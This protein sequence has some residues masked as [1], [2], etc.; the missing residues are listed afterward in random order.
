M[1]EPPTFP[2]ELWEHCISFIA[3]DTGAL[4]GLCRTNTL[5]R[6]LT[7]HRLYRDLRP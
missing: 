4:A 2:V 3:D 5:F 7:R 6:S 1:A